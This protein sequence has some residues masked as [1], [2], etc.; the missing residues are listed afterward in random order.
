MAAS[1]NMSLLGELVLCFKIIDANLNNL[2]F[3]PGIMTSILL[4]LLAKYK[5]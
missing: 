2:H 4:R 5:Y 3:I 1:A